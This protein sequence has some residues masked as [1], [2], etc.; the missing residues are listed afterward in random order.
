MQV[1]SLGQEDALET[2]T[3][4]HSSIVAWVISWTE[5]PGGLQS[6]GSQKESDTVQQLKDNNNILSV[7]YILG[8]ELLDCMIT[9]FM[10]NSQIFFRSG[11]TIL[12]SWPESWPMH[13]Y[14][15]CVGCYVRT[16]LPTLATVGFYCSILMGVAWY[17]VVSVCIWLMTNNVE[18]LFVCL[19]V[20]C[21][22][23]LDKVT[24]IFCVSKIRLFLL[25]SYRSSLCT[26]DI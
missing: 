14:Q 9:L 25:L 16:S 3:P 4:A 1:Q 12:L 6:V 26:L 11:C 23:S 7:G 2:G 20:I 15:R 24:E 19:L 5:E 13:S 10:R 21:I 8:M 18:L 17:L 22:S